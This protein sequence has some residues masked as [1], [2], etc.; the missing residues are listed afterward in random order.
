MRKL[1]DF[2][3]C[4]TVVGRRCEGID[5][6][7]G[8]GFYLIARDTHLQ[9]FGN[10]SLST[11]FGELT[12][13]LGTARL[14]VGIALDQEFGTLLL[15]YSHQFGDILEVALGGNGG[16]IEVEEYGDRG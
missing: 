9:Q 15:G 3:C 13:A 14:T 4:A 1:L 2:D 16:L 5:T 10:D 11:L 6:T 8:N 12:V 7:N